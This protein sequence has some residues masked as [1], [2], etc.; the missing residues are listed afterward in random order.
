MTGPRFWWRTLRAVRVR[1]GRPGG[2][3]PYDVLN[4]LHARDIINSGL[5]LEDRL[6]EAPPPAAGGLW[7]PARR[8]R[9]RP[10]FGHG[11]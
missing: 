10:R 5:P 7:R 6:D 8:R 4:R 2:E 11:R 9:R 1:R 3:T